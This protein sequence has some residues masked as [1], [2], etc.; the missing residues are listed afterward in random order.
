LSSEEIC[1]TL[2]ISPNNLWVM[3]HRAR[4]LLRRSSETS[5]F[6]IQD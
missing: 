5:W 6:A 4:A 2:N 3:L 1:K